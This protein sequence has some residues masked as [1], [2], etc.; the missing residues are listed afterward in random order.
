MMQV[1]TKSRHY[2]TN[3]HSF[4]GE[5]STKQTFTALQR[6]LYG[7]LSLYSGTFRISFAL[8]FCEMFIVVAAVHVH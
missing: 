4:A 5:V 6:K 2:A 8:T 7:A 3:M 1:H